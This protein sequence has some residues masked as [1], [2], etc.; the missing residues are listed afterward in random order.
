M[1]ENISAN[2]DELPGK[3][4]RLKN[5]IDDSKDYPNELTIQVI[6]D[7]E[8]GIGLSRAYDTVEEFMRDLMDDA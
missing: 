5:N 6:K 2:L 3:K 4:Y 7:A 1:L 8:R